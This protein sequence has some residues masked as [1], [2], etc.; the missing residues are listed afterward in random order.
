MLDLALKSLAFSYRGTPLFA[1]LSLAIT[2]RSHVAIVGLRGTGK[3][4]LLKLL[5][6]D[7]KP[8][9]GSIHIGTREV[10]GL[11][12][13]RRPLLYLTPTMEE[14][15]RWSVGHLLVAAVRQR[16][17]DREDRFIDLDEAAR[18]WE[19]QELLERPLRSL[20]SSELARA[21]CAQIELLRPGILVMERLLAGTDPSERR[22]LSDQLFRYLRT[23]GTTVIT[24]T[25]SFHDLGQCDTTV[26]LENGKVRSA[27]GIKQ[28]YDSPASMAAAKATGKVNL[29]PVTIKGNDVESP[30]GAWSEEQPPFQGDGIY[31]LR[32][33]HL[34]IAGRGEDSDF[35]LAVEEASF[36]EGFWLLRGYMSAG[37]SVIATASGSANVTKGKLLPYRILPH[38][39]HYEKRAHEGLGGVPRDG[40]PSI[41]D[42]R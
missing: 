30:I 4:T 12:R 3:S 39:R 21:R 13:K 15:S 33:E 32:P 24:E 25:V 16:P 40:I 27:G 19:V 18:R 17:L 35:I 29:V 14:P 8:S 28:A 37:Q 42:S 41:K 23:I 2:A 22:D 38:V 10:T 9:R 7:E 1:D 34:A 36:S 5:A 6:G 31:L 20:S 11:T 26:V